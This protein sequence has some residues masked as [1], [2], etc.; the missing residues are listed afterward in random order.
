MFLCLCVAYMRVRHPPNIPR[1]A[2]QQQKKGQNFNTN[3][4]L[5]THKPEIYE[6]VDKVPV[7]E[8]ECTVGDGAL[9][10]SILLQISGSSN[11]GLSVDIFVVTFPNT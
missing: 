4:R 1:V 8:L 5:N 9:R 2:G 11:S 7:I 6:R 3:S 10:V